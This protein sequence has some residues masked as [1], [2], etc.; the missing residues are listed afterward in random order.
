M[1]PWK[2]VPGYGEFEGERRLSDEDISLIKRWVVQGRQQGDPADLPAAPQW[3]IGWSLGKPD[4]VVTL[5]VP[6]VL[7]SDGADVFRSFVVP[8]PVG[9]RRY[10]RALEFDPGN[11]KAIH[12]A[13]LKIDATRSSR[14][15]DDQEPGPG[16]DGAGARGAK[17][18]DGYF[19]GWT[20]GQS[21]RV[22]ADGSSWRLESGSDL[23][24]ELHMM[25]TGRPETVQP[26]VGLYFTDRPPVH[27]PY[28][29]RLGRQ[30]LDIPAGASRYVSTDSY[31]VP[32]DVS[33]IAVQP[34]AHWLTRET[35]GFATLPDGSVKWLVYIKDWDMQWQDVYRL[36]APLRLPK[37]TRLTMEYTYDNSA[38]NVR[39]PNNP[40]RRVTFGQT[41]ASEM[42][43][44]WLQ[45]MTSSA[46]DRR[47]LDRDF[48]PKMLREDI[49][50]IEKILETDP[51]DP[52]LHADLGLCYVDAGR[53]GD[54]LTQLEEAARLQPTSAGAQHD[55]GAL[56]LKARRFAEA[57]RY[58]TA[59]IAL[60]PDFSE[61]YNNLGIVSH[62]EGKIDDAIGLYASATRIDPENAE[63]EYNLGRALVARGATSEA[64]SHYLRSLAIKPDDAVT[65]ASLAS[66]LSSRQEIVRAVGH[67]RRALELDPGLPAALVDLAWILATSPV[68][69]IRSPLEAVRLAERAVQV[70]DNQNSTALDTLATAYAA[71]GDF[72]RAIATA[73]RALA[74]ASVSGPHDLVED[75]RTR[76]AGYK[77]QR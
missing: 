61:A 14:W 62:A 44:L 57:R 28:M 46:E 30:D 8:I 26:R 53:I 16:Y 34:H 23:V 5:P 47:L 76:L 71:S 17:F 42:G 40:P 52:R 12:H 31:T 6:Y 75:I 49:A 20:P 37:G 65:H 45:V 67:Y 2:P 63:A 73:E 38:G 60:K 25:P 3:A 69:D 7:K 59:A 9:E 4:L 58:L 27:L 22:A 18:P 32:V 29:I 36:R 39:N 41:S 77:Q 54:A 11:A 50:G 15:L 70:T 1:P 24:I 13:N 21:P 10:V 35:S 56:L 33:I 74:V 43:D 51:H 55:V 72:D 48:A 64:V 19:L 66:L 68:A